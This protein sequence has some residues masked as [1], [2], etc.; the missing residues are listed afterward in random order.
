M[1]SDGSLQGVPRITTTVL[2][3]VVLLACATVGNVAEEKQDDS[4][5]FT[6]TP[7]LCLSSFSGSIKLNT[8]LWR[9]LP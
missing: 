4:W 3:T 8:R 6:I 9:Q 2:V 7:F 5:R 1:K